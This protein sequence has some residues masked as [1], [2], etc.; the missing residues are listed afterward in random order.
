MASVAAHLAKM[1]STRVGSVRTSPDYGMPDLNDMRLSPHDARSQARTAI[2]ALIESYEPR[3][4]SVCVASVPS[5]ADQLRLSF[6]IDALLV[7]DGG[8]QQVSFTACLDGR[9]QIKV[10]Q[11]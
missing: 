9:G 8:K 7:M 11:G 5:S 2:K 4:S 3:L 1:L 10:S 6:N